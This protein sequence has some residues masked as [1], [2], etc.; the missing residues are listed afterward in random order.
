MSRST[1][2]WSRQTSIVGILLGLG[3]ATGGGAL[4]T[5]DSHHRPTTSTTTTLT[6]APTSSTDTTSLTPTT[7]RQFP[8]DALPKPDPI[9]HP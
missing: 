8:L 5:V 2:L 1:S 4:A 3:L 9:L 7:T 6:A